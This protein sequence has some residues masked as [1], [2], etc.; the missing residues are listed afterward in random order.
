[1]GSRTTVITKGNQRT[2]A[3]SVG[4]WLVTR[5]TTILI[6]LTQ[7]ILPSA[8][9][10]NDIATLLGQLLVAALLNG[11]VSIKETTNDGLAIRIIGA[12]CGAGDNTDIELSLVNGQNHRIN[13]VLGAGIVAS[14]CLEGLAIG[15]RKLNRNVVATGGGN[16]GKQLAIESSGSVQTEVCGGK[17]ATLASAIGVVQSG[18]NPV[19]ESL[20]MGEPG[21]IKIGLALDILGR[22][23][24]LLGVL[25]ELLQG[26]PIS[27]VSKCVNGNNTAINNVDNLDGEGITSLEKASL[28][29]ASLGNASLGKRGRSSSGGH[30]VQNQSNFVLVVVN[31]NISITTL[32]IFYRKSKKV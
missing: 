30:F 15:S 8:V 9:H 20:V 13:S 16:A 23:S 2:I 4:E 10:A 18:I 26:K 12:C 27:L 29:N 22:Q 7:E 5:V 31:L 32:S 3:G 19:G 6:A 17:G 11:L 1:M 28:G 24:V 25:G 21:Q 14:E